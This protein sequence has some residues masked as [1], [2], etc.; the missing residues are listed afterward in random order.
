MKYS[1]SKYSK[2]IKLMLLVGLL[3]L[4]GVGCSRDTNGDRPF[5]EDKAEESRQDEIQVITPHTFVK[6]AE[7]Q[8]PAVVNISLTRTIKN[9]PDISRSPFE[10]KGGPLEEFFERFFGKGPRREFKQ[11]SLGSGFIISKEGYILTNVHVI[12]DVD[13][14]NIIL[15]NHKKFKAK[16]I[17]IDKKTDIAL[18]KIKSWKDLPTVSL[19]D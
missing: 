8:K 2:Y 16:L 9:H 1:K 10:K 7:E 3:W 6:V 18:I 11:K 12:N 5:I 19:G 14:I 15:S 4:V 13:E 17:G